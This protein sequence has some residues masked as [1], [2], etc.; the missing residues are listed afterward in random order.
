[1]PEVI[2]TGHYFYLYKPVSWKTTSTLVLFLW[3]RDDDGCAIGLVHK[4][5]AIIIATGT[6]EERNKYLSIQNTENV[7]ELQRIND[8]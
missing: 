8:D 2:R 5:S 6:D 7:D 1:M 3:D 4:Q